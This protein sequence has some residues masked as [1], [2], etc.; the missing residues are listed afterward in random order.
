M[1]TPG[2][3]VAERVDRDPRGAARRRRT[4]SSRR[5]RTTTTCCGRVHD[6]ALLD[7]LR[8]V[9]GRWVD[10]RLRRA[11]ARTGSCPYV[12]PTAGHAHGLPGAR[13]RPPCT[14]GAGRFC[15]DTMTLVGPGTWEAARAR[16]RLR[17]DRG[18]P[19]RRRARRRRTP[20]AGRPAT[21]R[22]RAAYGG[23]CYLNNAAVAAQALRDAGHERVAVVDL[24]AHHGN[25][26]QAI[27]YDR[28][29][30][31][32]RLAARRPRRRLVPALLR[33]RRRDRARARAR[34]RPATCRSR[35]GTGDDGW[36]EA[37][38]RARRRRRRARR[39]ALVVSL[40]V[41]AAA[42]DPESPLQVTADG[43]R[44]GRRAA[45]RGSGCR[46][47]SCRRA[48]TTWPPSAR[49]SRR[50][51]TASTARADWC[52]ADGL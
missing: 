13:R 42:D 39:D 4:G 14:P 44:R 18:R 9:C 3:E 30:R 40:G 41:D 32:L 45:R 10:G 50:P 28:A 46:P 27:F 2:T 6:P 29:R 19:G 34:A 24:D 49:S 16:R 20:C 26:T 1:R 47:C 8:T 15:Y 35:P 21:T 25:G 36:L 33:L 43:Y 23:S 38:A 17:A 5:R 51:S 31:A 11:R 52:A 22:R 12:F 48:A 37:V 7:H